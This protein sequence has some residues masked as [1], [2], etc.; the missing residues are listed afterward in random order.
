MKKEQLYEVIGDINE[1]YVNEARG[2]IKKNSRAV[3][4]KWVAVAASF[5][6]VIAIGIAFLQGPGNQPYTA[7]LSNGSEITFVKGE[8]GVSNLDI[9][10]VGIRALS[11]VETSA[12]F[13]NVTVDADVGFEEGTN[14]FIYLEGTVDGFDITVARSDI[15]PD[16]V[17]DGDE[18]VSDI[19]G[20]SVSAGY[21]LT[22]ANSQGNKTAIVYASF[23]VGNYTIYL[24]TSGAED[25]SEDLCNALAEEIQKLI[26]TASFDFSQIN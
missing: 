17:I 7:T 18:S 12:V 16:T 6:L 15:S 25:E 26:D 19:D 22:K 9:A 1:N 3:W 21:F 13:G 10:L 14:E 8:H 20:V 23:E 11:E 2:T 4:T 24:E 5:A